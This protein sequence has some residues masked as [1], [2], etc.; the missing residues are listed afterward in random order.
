MKKQLSAILAVSLIASN[1]SPMIDIYASELAK[2]TV[3]DLNESKSMQSVTA[4]ITP[5]TLTNY[6]NFESYNEQFKIATSQIKSITN[7]GGQYSSS[8]IDKAIDGNLSTHW[9]TGKQNNS[10]F[11][12]EV[13][14]EFEEVESINRLIYAT[15]QDSAKGKGFPTEFE[16]YGS[17][18]GSDEDYQLLVTGEHKTTGDLLE[19]KFPTMTVKKIKF[20][21][22]EANQNWASA[23]EFWFYK[24][25]A[26][27][28]QMNEMFTNE[29]K[30]EL[31]SHV[32]TLEKL[33]EFEA[34]VMNH[35]LYDEYKEDFNNA[36][37]LLESM[38]VVYMNAI[39]SK[40]T[41]LADERLEA[42]DELYKIPS[43]KITSITTN[44][45][46]YA[47][48][49]IT[50][51]IDGNF[52]TN[53]HSGKQ[54]T[55]T[56]TNEVIVTLDELTTVNRIMYTNNRSRGFAQEFE[57][58]ISKTSQ[59]ET[60]EKVTS[61]QMSID[62]NH[63]MEI[64]FNPTEARRIKFVFTK[65][66]ED[67]AVAS[68]F[69]IYKQDSLSEMMNRLFVD[70]SMSEI[71][72]EFGTLG[73]LNSLIE[74]SK[75]HPFA[76]EYLEKLNL[77]KE[78]IEFGVIQSGTSNVSKFTPFYTDYI[79]QYDEQFR[80][81][82]SNISNNG[83]SYGGAAI[84]YA[85]DE[86][87]TTHWETGTPNSETFKNE[88]VL[89]LD[90]A[91]EIDRLT[92]KARTIN[93]G[94]PTKFSIYISPVG[95]GDNFQKVSEG[96][97][98]V[99]N[100][101]LEIKFDSTKA[102]RIKFV[103]EEAYQDR[104][105][106]GDIRVYKEDT[107]LNQMKNLFTDGLMDTVSEAYNTIEKLA[108]LEAEVEGHPLATVYLEEIQIAKDILNGEL[109]T[110]KTVVAEQ[111]GDRNAHASQNLKFGFG[112][113][114]QST[115]IVALAGKEITVYV[116]A[117]PGQPLPQL[118]F[119]Q[120]E[121]SFA[122]WG[123][124][125]SLH[126]GKNVITVPTVSQNDGWYN[127]SVTPGGAVY[128][129]N[130]Y[131][132]EQQSKAP[133]IRFA[134]GVE[135]FPMMD[136]NTNEQ[137]FLDL[138]K[139]YKTRLDA[140]KAANPDV[141]D[142]QMIDVVEVVSDHLVFTGT[143]TGAYTAY[144][145]QEFGP[146]NTVNMYNDHMDMV[147][148]YLGLDGS[149]L[150]H[151]VK[152]TRENIR[153]AQPFGYMYAAGN[154]IGVQSDVMVSMLTSIGGWGVDHE[155][156]H[157]LDIGVRTIG[158]VTNNMI[159]QFSSYYYNKPNKR[160][161]FESHVYKNVIAT[162]N[163]AYYAGG[164]FEQLA[165]F[166]QLEMIYP[167]Y[168][169][170]L[171]SLY[172]ENNVVLDSSNTANDKLNQL[173]KYSSIALELDLTEH[174]ERHGFF[175]SDETK[176]FTRQY[177][178]PNVKTWYANYD[179]IEYE[180]TGFD[181]NVTTALNLSTLSDQIKLTFHVNQSASNDVMGYEI[182]KSGELI[183][184]TS[185]NSFI[186]TEAVIGEQVEYTVV[187]YDKTLHT[188]TPV[189][190]QSLS[191]SLHVQQETYTIK[192]HESF[193]PMDLVKATNYLGEDMTDS[194]VVS[195]AVNTE[196]KGTYSVEY[197]VEDHGV[198]ATKTI[199]VIVVSDYDYLSD[200]QWSDSKL[201]YGTIRKTDIKGRV[202]GDIKNFEN[203]LRI[204][205]TSSVTYDLSDLDYD[206]FEALV[207]VDMT[208]VEQTNS[209][210]KFVIKA[211]GEVVAT[212]NTLRHAD[213]MVAIKVPVQG[214]NELVI[215]V[216]DAGN[217]NTSDHGVIA[218]PILT[219]NNAKPSL[220]VMDQT[221]YLGE[222]VDFRAGLNATDAEDGDLT[223][224]IEIISNNFEENKVGRFEVTYRV[225]D[226]DGNKVEKT[227]YVVVYED[228]TVI[229]S[230]YGQ[231]SQLAAYNEM[232]KIPVASVSNNAGHYGSSVIANAITS[233]LNAHWETNSPNSPTFKNE[234]V[235]DLGTNSDVATMTYAGRRGGKGFATKFEVYVSSEATGNDFIYAGA[236]TYTG[237]TNDVIQFTLNRQDVRRV[238]FVFVEANQGWASIGNVSFYKQDEIAKKLQTQLF[239]DE[240]QTEVAEA[241]NT[242]EKLNAFKEEIQA[243]YPAYELFE[244]YFVKAEQ[245]LQAKLPVLTV[246][247]DIAVKVGET[248]ENIAGIYQAIDQEDGD[249][250]PSVIVSGLEGINF[251]QP[252]VYSIHYKVA[253]SD[254]NTVEKTRHISVVNLEDF[255]YL[256]DYDW[257]SA[258][259]SY[260]STK[261]DQSA[262][263]NTLRLTNED[264]TVATYERGIG[265]HSTATIIY[266]LSDKNYDIFS[267]YVGVDRAMHGSVGSVQFEVFVDNELAF[268]S[269]VMNSR[270][271]KK[272]VEVSIAGAK[273]LKLV[274]KD[275]GN[276]DGSDHATWGDTKLHF[277]NSESV[278]IDRTQLDDLLTSISELNANHYTEASW[279]E[280]I[281]VVTRVNEQLAA[282]YT[283]EIINELTTQ[284]AQALEQL[285]VATNYELLIELVEQA[286]LIDLEG[287]TEESI[288]LLQTTINQAMEMLK[289]NDSQQ[290]DVNQMIE[291]L[292]SA[293]NG[294]EEII[295][296][297]QVIEFE[298]SI[299]KSA[300]ISQLNLATTEI[301]LGDLL[302]L[303]ELNVSSSR[304]SSLKGLEYANNLETLDI[305]YNEI[306]DLSPLSSLTKLVNVKIE[307]QIIE[308][309]MLTPQDG[310]IQFKFDVINRK[311]ENL[312]PILSLRNN[313]T[314][315]ETTLET[316][317]DE[318]GFITIDVNT[319]DSGVYTLYVGF[320]DHFDDLQLQVLY[321]F[322][323]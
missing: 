16:I 182:F 6:R 210:I 92:Y 157:R 19:F 83:G 226:S 163:N 118:V 315:E 63:T 7:N 202:N 220:T 183:G 174:F 197:T 187:T 283:Q 130:P 201:G 44:G 131:T 216:N 295:D 99:T 100:D 276:G 82:I 35:P 155:M 228:F 213:N 171:N 90:K 36:R 102:K 292:Q 10:S 101:M 49:D 141:M 120:Q 139:D 114:F 284:L 65:G 23:S 45:G 80:V 323:K 88:V 109:Q 97:Y 12:N 14:F 318:N 154:H 247:K 159:P 242:F 27:L 299:L 314:F 71:T 192:L 95:S 293:I 126:I 196:E 18:S 205:A 317:I 60:F 62:T 91:T 259:Q 206:Y 275:G 144:I 312:L 305:S 143:A 46:Q 277:A 289:A 22:K 230:K 64:L 286:N 96:G 42:Y 209:S 107:V 146:M 133:I 319:L 78:L 2:E 15:R 303:T 218:H 70:P 311:G 47:S 307:Y 69:G 236:G 5:F 84:N 152:Y 73:A 86:D 290:A 31:S 198:T 134:E 268:D 38:E 75:N 48:N 211:D 1:F 115:G 200:L 116:D 233:D 81:N 94:F 185:T 124:T 190:I 212:T 297:T 248:L 188:A 208:I 33:N 203:G 40:F 72:P 243:S 29:S 39:V 304:I 231:F 57:I 54:N 310:K 302:K 25:D 181:D 260:G 74:L 265:A 223:E 238:K 105:S 167:G 106:I 166:W 274:V 244:A 180:G 98:T 129:L 178:K 256:T 137:E 149:S 136:A 160:I 150:Q 158:E 217:G 142:R 207:G 266:D 186:D 237:N 270:D 280:L 76:D 251:N 103:F 20:V 175:V 147:F 195:G 108:V 13:V 9:E 221:Y 272:Y 287:Y 161:P 125:V 156:G 258:K 55:S 215:E 59:G 162:D 184:F 52:N 191:P 309:G 227:A 249:I 300:I 291:K 87:V 214:V 179:Y 313:R 320:I 128:I 173:A 257:T 199:L 278:G 50:K 140:D 110:I 43:E 148:D 322:E 68:E 222:A 138:L 169:G 273:Q 193:N 67:W 153:L 111:H 189:S 3:V 271:A 135:K 58:Y 168:W 8:S 261:K 282:G 32:D 4:T 79:N 123:R 285:I 308:G 246:E 267:A 112:D 288:A 117:E 17:L 239:T 298:D 113:N 281:S 11:K 234:V 321:M 255:D 245:V 145:E 24:E 93:K 165:V 26:I 240:T 204:H 264:G 177:E 176:E 121:G 122:N 279:S 229:K 252:G 306:K 127:H 232:F 132:E 254:G 224:E 164:Y 37:V 316:M 170:K 235:F 263:S 225:S 41:S 262:S 53:W 21:F 51:A 28:E 294:L 34:T 151:D 66:Y 301:K 253:D 219:T 85:I 89:T 30:N 269:G 296:L 104:P 119:S 77:A 241:Y 61:G 56:H 250:T 194:I 172:R